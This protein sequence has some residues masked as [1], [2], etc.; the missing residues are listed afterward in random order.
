LICLDEGLEAIAL[1]LLTSI[2]GWE[3]EEVEVLLAH[4][5]NEL[6]DRKIHAQY[7]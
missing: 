3:M 5:R 2:L 6:K 4:V 1:R 7:N